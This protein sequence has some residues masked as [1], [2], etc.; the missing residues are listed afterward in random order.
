MVNKKS[1]KRLKKYGIKKVL[2]SKYLLA[3]AIISILLYYFPEHVYTFQT[4]NTFVKAAT[5]VSQSLIAVTLTG[6]A[7]LVSFSDKQFLSFFRENGGFDE[8]LFIFEYTVTLSII[9]T[10]FGVVLQ[11]FT[12]KTW[13]FFVYIFSFLHLLSSMGALV[14]TILGFATR[15]ADYEAIDNID[16]ADVPDEL[17]EDMKDIIEDSDGKEPEEKSESKS[18]SEN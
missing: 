3:P 7:I 6:L 13:L 11:S 16:G 14:S 1:W 10:L 4:K 9:V 12:H 5:G 18:S 17:K 2:L 8:L 15:K